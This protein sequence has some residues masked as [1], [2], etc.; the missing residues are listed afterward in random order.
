M[1]AK[2]ECWV[3][4]PVHDPGYPFWDEGEDL[5]DVVCSVCLGT[6]SMT[7][8]GEEIRCPNCGKKP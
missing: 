7:F 2:N 4:R 6:K 8:N 5:S 3:G 1:T